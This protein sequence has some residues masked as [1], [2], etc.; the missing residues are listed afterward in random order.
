MNLY[1]IFTTTLFVVLFLRGKAGRAERV[2]GE[3]GKRG[4]K[5]RL[6]E[7]EDEERGD[8]KEGER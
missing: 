1:I 3:K 4:R 8:G 6:G 2:G 7:N 5:R